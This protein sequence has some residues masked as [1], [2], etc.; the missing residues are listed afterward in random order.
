MTGIGRPLDLT[1]QSNRIA[2]A[3][4]GLGTAVAA[5]AGW[6]R[7]DLSILAP[8]ISGLAVFLAWAIARELTPDYPGAATIAI[9][10]ALAGVLVAPPSLVVSAVALIA[11]RLIAG[12]VGAAISRFDVVALTLLGVVSGLVAV[13]WITAIAIAVWAWTAPEV[14][15]R[16]KVAGSLFIVGVLSGLALAYVLGGE[17]G[18]PE[19]AI[20]TGAYV[21]TAFAAG[22]MLLAARPTQVIS[23]IDAGTTQIDVARIRLARLAAG[24]FVMWAAVIGGEPGFWAIAPV[25]AALIVTAIYRIFREPA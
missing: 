13:L 25:M 12:T 5:G 2:V 14:G 16:R 11:L 1:L 20:T 8:L 21:L 15:H 4:F 17:Y 7:G 9:V 23:Q 10:L 18:R 24:A 6:Y 22:V 19:V 3:G